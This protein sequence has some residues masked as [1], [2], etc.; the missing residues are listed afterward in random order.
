MANFNMNPYS[1]STLTPAVL[2]GADKGYGAREVRFTATLTM[3]S[4][5]SGSTLTAF[6]APAGYMF[7]GGSL[8]TTVTLGTA[9]LAIG[10]TNGGAV[11]FTSNLYR[12]AAVLTTIS[13]PQT[14][15][16][17]GQGFV[18]DPLSVYSGPETFVMTVGTAALPSS[19]IL[20]FQGTFLTS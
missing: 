11:A 4:Q 10:G 20:V 3:A 13:A 17:G 5:A 16:D 9:T 8:M 19:G 1:G 6:K 15:F 14:V 18:T 12:A 7:V 2:P